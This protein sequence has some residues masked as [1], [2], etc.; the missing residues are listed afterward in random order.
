MMGKSVPLGL[1]RRRLLA[2]EFLL[3]RARVAAEHVNPGTLECAAMEA[4]EIMLSDL[5]H[6]Y[7]AFEADGK[8]GDKNS[9]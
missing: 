6:K 7:L 3:S 4:V 2:A 9:D 1:I 8:E 5:I